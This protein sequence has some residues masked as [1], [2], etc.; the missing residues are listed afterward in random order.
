MPSENTTNANEATRKDEGDV[1]LNNAD[2]ALYLGIDPGT[3]SIWRHTN[4][5]VIPYIKV[6]RLVRYRVRD[7]DAFLAARTVSSESSQS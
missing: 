4:R 1:R 7:L 5:Y 3:L 2:A 6:G